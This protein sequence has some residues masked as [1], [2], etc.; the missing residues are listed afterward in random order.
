MGSLAAAQRQGVIAQ[1]TACGS[2]KHTAGIN[3]Q[4]AAGYATAGHDNLSI[5]VGCARTKG[6]IDAI[7][8]FLDLTAG[9]GQ[10]G[11][12]GLRG[13]IQNDVGAQ[14]AGTASGDGSSGN[15]VGVKVSG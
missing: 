11:H 10:H 5:T 14:V 7:A 3:N 4:S 12:V 6:N 9:N 2:I 8:R 1:S 13:A 15:F